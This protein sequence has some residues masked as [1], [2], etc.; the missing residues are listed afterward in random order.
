MIT[1]RPH[2]AAMA[3]YPLPAPADDP[4]CVG[5]AQNE[6]AFPPSPL[7]IAAAERAARN[8]AL[9]PDAGWVDLRAALAEVHGIDANGIVCG[10][11][12]MDLISGLF[13]TFVGPGD[14]VVGS[15]YGYL[16]PATAAQQV[17]AQLLHADERNFTVDVDALAARAGGDAG[18]AATEKNPA[19]M[20]F[21]C[22]PGNPTGTRIPNAEI[23]RLRSQLDD[24]TLL[25]VDQAYGEFDDQ[26]QQSAFDLVARGDTVVLR[27]LS[28]AYGLAGLRVGWGYFPLRVADELRKV[29]NPNNLSCIAQAMA[30]VAVR[31]QS[32]MRHV[33]AQTAAVRDEFAKR[34]RAMGYPIPES[35]TNFVLIPFEDAS[36]CQRVDRALQDAGF[37]LRGMSGYG[38]P[39]CLRATV[40]TAE[41]MSD[42]ADLLETFRADQ[43]TEL[44]A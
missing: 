13:Q 34:L 25:V 19:R 12:S 11:G 37:M 20:V 32:Y 41:Q 14:T 7:A 17:G 23:V 29:M 44:T 1:A 22:N 26:D 28:K 10:V 5:L 3:A 38:L 43:Q 35:H 36:L 6:S 42:V 30:E 40:G 16:F 4:L 8:A 31:D 27:T 18:V 9:Y 39:H 15:Q 24:R 33:V 21:V 2:V